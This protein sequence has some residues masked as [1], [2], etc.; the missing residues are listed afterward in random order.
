[1]Q[2]WKQWLF[3]SKGT[4]EDM[5]LIK[6]PRQH[7]PRPTYPT[8]AFEPLFESRTPITGLHCCF[9]GAVEK[10]ERLGAKVT[11]QVVEIWN[12]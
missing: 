8:I 11:Y 12:A 2:I 7:H 3:S 4:T 5:L 1:M 10:V 9:G 6:D